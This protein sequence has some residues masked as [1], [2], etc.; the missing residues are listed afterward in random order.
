MSL[1]KQAYHPINA[2][3]VFNVSSVET[4]EKYY[5]GKLQDNYA[6]CLFH[7]QENKTSGLNIFLLDKTNYVDVCLSRLSKDLRDN[8]QMNHLRIASNIF[9]NY[10]RNIRNQLQVVL[11]SI[12]NLYECIV[13]TCHI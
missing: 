11:F 13:I 8:K 6:G 7:F 12:F 4:L 2:Y 10:L 5:N 1:E 9:A 3:I